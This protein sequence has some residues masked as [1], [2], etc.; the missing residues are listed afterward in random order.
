[1]A[2]RVA[3]TIAAVRKTAHAEGRSAMQRRRLLLALTVSSSI[4]LTA[5][6]AAHAQAAWPSQTV[7]IVVPTGPGSSLD[8]IVRLLSD[9][10]AARWGQ[11][12]VVDNKPGAGGM[13]G[14]GV[15]AKATDD[16]TIAIGFNGPLAYAP[17]LYNKTPYDP[18]KDLRP[19]VMTSSQA[20][21]LAV[22]ADKVPAKT[23]AEFIAWAKAQDGKMNFSS[24]GQGSSAHM[25]MELFLAEAGLKAVHVPFNG[26]PPA[27]MA[28]AQGTVDAT[29]MVAPALLPH[30]QSGK[31][32]LLAVSADSKPAGLGALPSMAEAGYP[33]VKALAWNGLVGPASLS[34]A[35]V[36]RI[37]ADVNA[38]LHDPAVRDAMARS[39]LTIVGG[40]AEDFRRFIADDVGRW[41]PV[42]TRLGVKLN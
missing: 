27:A 37:N 16:H 11:T 20:N 40:S 6:M 17:F 32:R 35:A 5:H 7:K 13:L 39:G 33:A 25:T 22:N 42:I 1:M 15:A 41:G 4:A 12:V 30:V 18:A 21:V 2:R 8:L 36:A 31:V 19:I 23:V 9:K 34:D 10:L 24:L 28:V 3:A 14:V 26:S 29:W 38:V